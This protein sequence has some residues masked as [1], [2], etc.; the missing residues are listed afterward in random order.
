[1]KYRF[2]KMQSLGNDFV[3]LNGVVERIEMTP[4]IA[5][6][7]AD[8]HFGI[9]CDQ[10]LVAQPIAQPHSGKRI[11]KSG[12][13]LRIF[14]SDGSEVGQCGNGAR[15][16]ARYLHDQGLSDQATIEVETKTTALQLRLNQDDTVTVAMGSPE[17]APQKI[18]LTVAGQLPS[19]HA[20]T[21][22]GEVEF[23]ALS[24]GNP[25][26]VIQVDSVENADVQTIGPLLENHQLFPERANIGFMQIV[27]RRE[28]KL[29]VHER[30]AGETLGCGS[31]ACAAV[32]S[33]IRSGLLDSRVEVALPG[34]RARVDWLGAESQ[35]YL[36]GPVHTVYQGSIE[37]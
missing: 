15:C 28:I 33:G 16:F 30:G 20:T 1:M 21:E 31:G 29:R 24:L 18:P 35:I 32:V 14:N 22:F 4:T 26:G 17:F 7:I 34:G 9:G 5:R 10:I 8:R 37:I 11:N 12:Y 36:T 23:S 25:H 13:R 27:S 6:H 3:M 2:T 19:Y